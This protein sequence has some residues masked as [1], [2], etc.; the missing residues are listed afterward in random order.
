[1]SELR[2][3]IEL[4]KTTAD[5]EDIAVLFRAYA[6]SLNIDLS[7]QAFGEELASLP[8][9]YSPPQGALLLARNVQGEPVG[10]VGLRPIAHEGCCE[11]K[12]LYVAPGGR[13]VGLGKAL[14]HAIIDQA[15][16]LG[17]SEMRLDTL[18]TMDTAIA[19]YRKTGFVCIPPYYDTP[20]EGTIFMALSLRSCSVHH[21]FEK[22]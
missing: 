2:F 12:R 1:M 17:Y 10:C 7:Y 19:L 6:A 3:N 16:R 5:I 8:G 9:K 20:L 21:R 14:L 15:I 13:G 11:M 18:P 22:D 4:V